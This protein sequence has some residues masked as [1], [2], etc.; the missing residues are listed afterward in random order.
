[1]R[2]LQ[3]GDLARHR[4]A[5]VGLGLLLA[6]GPAV[7]AQ[8][9]A[10]TIAVGATVE[11]RFGRTDPVVMGRGAFHAYRFE[12]VA[13]GR[14]RVT[15]RS[16]DVDAYVWVAEHVG[17][18]T[19]QVASDD[20]GGG[21]TDAQLLFRPSRAG[22]YLIVAQSLDADETGAYTLVVESVPPPVPVSGTP[23]V[24]GQPREGA[25]LSEGPEMDDGEE[26]VVYAAYTLTGRGERVR[27]TVRSGAFDAMVRVLRVGPRGETLVTSD[28]DA[29]G[30]TDAEAT[31]VADGTFRIYVRAVDPRDHGG[32]IIAV[33]SAPETE[34][35]RD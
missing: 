31:F 27:V 8:E 18:L 10:R 35:P 15:M 12:A 6:A 13:G 5:W 17:G 21:D 22:T 20:D 19:D 16:A 11:G 28:D 3:G 30:G 34:R 9:S 26:T 29:G 14:Y 2:P 7:G 25:L 1:M 24:V 23:L 32:F 33:A 4:A